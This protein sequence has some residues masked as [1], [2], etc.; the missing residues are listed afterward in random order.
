MNVQQAVEAPTVTSTAFAASTYPQEVAGQL[1]LPRILAENIGSDLSR[2]GHRINVVELQQPY[3]QTLS[4]AGGVKMIMIDPDN[5]V[6]M[7]GVSP[8]KNN[9]V[10][11]L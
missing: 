1:T 3:M 5:G 4:G 9:Y 2:R 7:G 11:G 8:A 6:M 10:V